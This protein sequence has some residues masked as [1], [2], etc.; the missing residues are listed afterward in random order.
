MYCPE[1]SAPAASGLR[2]CEAC[3]APFDGAPATAPAPG[4]RVITALFTDISGFTSMS[5]GLD[6][7]EVANILNAFFKVLVDP[8]YRYGGVVDKYIGDAVM[9]VFGAPVAHEDD[10]VRACMAAWDMQA[11]A[12]AFS[13][14]LLKRTGID[15]KIRIGLN[16]G[17]AVYAAIGSHYKADTTVMGDTV[18]VAQR[19]ESH[20][21]AGRVLV[22]AMTRRAIG[23]AFDVRALPPI[24]V[25]GKAV[26]LEAFE[27][28][29]PRTQM[30]ML[31]RQAVPLIGRVAEL[32]QLEAAFKAASGGRPQIVAVTGDAGVGKS[33][34][35]RHFLF[36][37]QARGAAVIRARAQS[38]DLGDY[39]SVVGSVVEDMFSLTPG[40]SGAERIARIAEHPAVRRSRK[41]MAPE[42]LAALTT[43]DMPAASLAQLPPQALKEAAYAALSDALI[44]AAGANTLLVSLANL[45][46]ADAG[47]L[48]WLE[49]FAARLGEHAGDLRIVVV[50]QARSDSHMK[51]PDVDEGVGLRILTVAPLAEAEARA[52]ALACLDARPDDLAPPVSRLVAHVVSQSDGNPFYLTEILR[53]LV[54]DGIV[55]RTEGTWESG[56]HAE[57]WAVPASVR[58]A[59]SARLDRLAQPLRDVVQAAAILGRRFDASLLRVLAGADIEAA[60]ADLVALKI[61]SALPHD[62]LEFGQAVVQDVAYDSLLARQRSALH[63][64]AAETIEAAT[65]IRDPVAPL[66]GY[67]FAAG[68]VA[69]KAILY[70]VRAAA[71]AMP[72]FNVEEA[73]A[74]LQRAVAIHRKAAADAKEGLPPIG[75]LL[76]ELALAEWGLGRTDEALAHLAEA[77]A[78]EG[79]RPRIFRIRGEILA[80]RGDLDGATAAYRAVSAPGFDS[81]V[82]AALALAGIAD[83]HRRLADFKKAIALSR[84]ALALLKELDRPADC[85]TAHG[86]LGLCHFRLGQH[87]E[88]LAEHSGALQLREAIGDLAG[89]ARSLNNLG[90]VESG[91]GRWEAAQEHYARSLAIW[92]KLGDRRNIGVVLNNLGD[93]HWRQ[94]R[95]DLAE[96]HFAEALKVASRGGDRATSLAALGS[97]AD[98]L[99]ARGEADGALAHADRC[100]DLIGETGQSEHLADIRRIR[101]LALASKGEFDAA[102]AELELARAAAQKAGM[103]AFDA[104]VDSCLSGIADARAAAR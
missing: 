104:V 95:G 3:G 7:E 25:K 75:T 93:L 33:A 72:T 58:S 101:G 41:T 8:I 52:L 38:F 51:W 67:H 78:E 1:C 19:M 30:R 64:R 57:A 11:N 42:L 20:A 43:A 100:L 28:E 80:R 50:C 24:Q 56:P 79:P 63:R 2:F 92:R 6:P 5:E 13:A 89:V 14:D 96:R 36:G 97:L 62:R 27:L 88:A 46:W 86:V 44:A 59:V 69:S 22:S 23:D 82:E 68:E 35:V 76:L 83:V 55:V 34:V 94:Q 15:L 87:H 99:V 60:L 37:A 70:L 17:L 91:F 81:P 73:A 26:P 40:L 90:M 9:A 45:Q 49:Q 18:N 85:A 12:R 16:T 98:V 21:Q 32:G 39:H 4:R 53:Q 29:R 31:T 61:F 48:A 71:L 102:I 77:E 66:L 103:T 84:S 10:A 65:E 54:D 74:Y 47:S